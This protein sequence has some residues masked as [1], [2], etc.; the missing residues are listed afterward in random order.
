[1]LN[2]RRG[3]LRDP[4]WILVGVE[5]QCHRL[6]T[7]GIVLL[8]SAPYDVISTRVANVAWVCVSYIEAISAIDAVVIN[9]KI[10]VAI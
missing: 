10:H 8:Q 2:A 3:E 9:V 7:N 1:V 6:I 4:A 5:W